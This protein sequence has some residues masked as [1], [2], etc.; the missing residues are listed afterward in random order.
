MD[1]ELNLKKPGNDIL[2]ELKRQ[3]LS[4]WSETIF[5]EPEREGPVIN[6]RDYEA[7]FISAE[8]ET[9][10]YRDLRS[11][12][13]DL[14]LG[15]LG[16]RKA[17]L[18]DAIAYIRSATK[19][20]EHEISM[21]RSRLASLGKLTGD[22]TQ[23]TAA[24]ELQLQIDQLERELVYL[25]AH[26]SKLDSLERVIKL[27]GVETTARVSRSAEQMLR[28]FSQS[29]RGFIKIKAWSNH[30]KEGAAI[31]E[32]NKYKQPGEP[33]GF[34]LPLGEGSR[35]VAVSKEA[36]G[37]LLHLLESINLLA[38][39]YRDYVC[40]EGLD[41]EAGWGPAHRLIRAV[42]ELFYFCNFELPFSYVDLAVDPEDTTQLWVFDYNTGTW[43]I[44]SEDANSPRSLKRVGAEAAHMLINGHAL[45][46]CNDE[47]E[48]TRLTME[49]GPQLSSPGE[50]H[51]YRLFLCSGLSEFDLDPA[52]Q[53]VK[54]RMAFNS[55]GK[56]FD[57]ICTGQSQ[58]HMVR[59]SELGTT[60][61]T[62][63]GMALLDSRVFNF[64][65]GT[66]TPDPISRYKILS[67]FW[68]S[69]GRRRAIAMLGESYMKQVTGGLASLGEQGP[70][71]PT[72]LT[73]R[74]GT[75]VGIG[76]EAAAKTAV[77][78][79]AAMGLADQIRFMDL[80]LQS[81]ALTEDIIERLRDVH[82][83]GKLKRVIE[84]IPQLVE[85]RKENFVLRF[86][87]KWIT[88]NQ[89][90]WSFMRSSM[91][92]VW[93][94]WQKLATS[95]PWQLTEL[96][97]Y[98]A[99][100]MLLKLFG[101]IVRVI[102][103]IELS[104]TEIAQSLNIEA[105][106]AGQALIQGME[107]FLEAGERV[108]QPIA[109]AINFYYDPEIRF[110]SWLAFATS[111]RRFLSTMQQDMRSLNFDEK[112]LESIDLI[113]GQIDILYPVRKP[114]EKPPVQAAPVEELV[115]IS[116]AV[117]EKIEDVIAVIGEGDG[118][119][120][121]LKLLSMASRPDKR[122]T[123]ELLH[124]CRHIIEQLLPGAENMFYRSLLVQMPR[125]AE[126]FYGFLRKMLEQGIPSDEALKELRP[127]VTNYFMQL[128]EIYASTVS[129]TENLPRIHPEGRARLEAYLNASPQK[130]SGLP[131]LVMIAGNR[132]L[133]D[134][135]D[136]DTPSN[137]QAERGET[138]FRAYMRGT[139]GA[140]VE[141]PSVEI[142]P[143][144]GG[145]IFSKSGACIL[146][147]SPDGFNPY[148]GDLFHMLQSDNF[149]DFISTRFKL[150]TQTLASEFPGITV[151]V[152]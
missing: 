56:I 150:A 110:D 6:P 39:E 32:L 100:G 140:V 88:S 1:N 24:Y 111:Y 41:P 34:L 67:Q 52:S 114:A 145:R 109:E 37:Y 25:R 133:L 139:L 73:M 14:G 101:D 116:E 69:I 17:E 85:S 93:D 124:S 87:S 97:P 53:R 136:F 120:L 29:W 62:L 123:L 64:P 91:P 15:L 129:L 113:V 7:G 126:N 26:S 70:D 84:G 96:P 22:L 30:F 81:W 98:Q 86:N 65:T 148:W 57:A 79:F 127:Q 27:V 43:S 75:V 131:F 31:P 20:R 77:N 132:V 21:C 92:V 19:K 78:P 94:F 141:E 46:K 3:R 11:R 99:L 10:L 82:S 58:L 122:D 90:Y 12:D 138:Q 130:S 4:F 35:S 44:V 28:L 137:I 50:A 108:P 8:Q 74:V 76:K 36:A 55:L 128:G 60:L 49:E 33:V 54:F 142:F 149:A 5:D 2:N 102:L 112:L 59:S 51:D 61:E 40:A 71:H 135:G 83:Q 80:T 105:E 115:V 9:L 42:V 144:G 119:W 18:A 104:D 151:L 95:E 48:L 147:S 89:W 72:F 38:E 143:I 66:A 103:V 146:S 106:S 47:K 118:S 23:N 68:R 134:I 117:S 13:S 107:G 125:M 45:L 16:P 63:L 121:K 152:K